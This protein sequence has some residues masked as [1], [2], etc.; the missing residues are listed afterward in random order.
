MAVRTENIRRTVLVVEDEFVNSQLLGFILSEEYNV[1]YAEDGRKALEVL[2]ENVGSISMVLTDIK[3]PVMDGFEL[4]REIR[5]DE[6]F[7]MIPI[8]VLTSES[9]YEEKSLDLGAIDFLTKPYDM[10]SII[11]ARVRRIIELS[12]GRNIIKATEKDYLTGLYAREFFFEYASRRE[13]SGHGGM[14]AVVIDLD[15]F[16]VINSLYGRGFGNSVLKAV[17]TSLLPLLGEGDGIAC[18]FENDIFYVL[19]DHHDSYDSLAEKI[20]SDLK[21]L[22]TSIRFS[23]RIGVLP[24]VSRETSLLQQFETARSAC[25]SIKSDRHH[26]VAFYSEE[27]HKKELL[28]E[29]L[30]DE[31]QKALEEHQFVVWFQ[32]KFN[33]RGDRPVLCSSEALVRWRHPELGMVSPGVFIPLFERN[34]LISKLDQYVWNQAARQVARCKARYGSS[35][36]V[37]VNVSRIDLFDTDLKQTMLGIVKENGLEFRDFLLEVTE[38]AYSEDGAQLVGAIRDLRDAGFKIEMDDFGSGYSSLNSLSEMPVDIIK[39]DMSFTRKIHENKT[40]LRVVELIVEMA[41]SLGALVVAEGVETE[42]Q[43]Q[44]LKQVGCDCVQGYFFSK[45]LPAA[46]FEAFIESR[47]KDL[48]VRAI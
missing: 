29:R 2:K 38:S 11:K 36:P 28:E 5:S 3:M 25:N 10:P 30:L 6:S 34:A 42:V 24:D 26:S 16:H 37:S 22:S 13:T 14:D 43:Y 47:I 33:I 21:S 27:M 18:R 23:V 39:L 20:C 7:G 4:I 12:E 48:E 9:T 40:T 32:P 8:M 35:V 31:M 44:L 45:P 46:E 41:K 19:C 17:A 15:R 1:L